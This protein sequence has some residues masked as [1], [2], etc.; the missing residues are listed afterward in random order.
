MV[1]DPVTIFWN[2]ALARISSLELYPE[3]VLMSSFYFSACIF[4]LGVILYLLKLKRW[5]S[6][7]S[8]SETVSWVSI[9]KNIGRKAHSS[10]W[11]QPGIQDW[12]VAGTGLP[13]ISIPFWSA[14]NTTN[15]TMKAASQKLVMLTPSTL[16]VPP[17]TQ[18][19]YPTMINQ[20]TSRNSNCPLPNALLGIKASLDCRLW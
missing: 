1:S 9:A 19:K 6:I 10:Q 16:P 4:Y 14:L 13:A 20:T 8:S 18:V 11:R 12:S 7:G 17:I 5:W 15:E 2:A 3:L